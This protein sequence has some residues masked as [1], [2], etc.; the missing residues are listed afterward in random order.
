[1]SCKLHWRINNVADGTST[2]LVPEPLMLV[3]RVCTGIRCLLGEASQ[4]VVRAWD[5]GVAEPKKLIHGLK[6]G[7]ALSLVSLFYY[8]R[9]L[10]EG[11]GGNAMWAIM[12]VVVVFEFTVG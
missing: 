12:T 10:Y 1:M 11:V 4:F 6:V 9:P 7:M 5:M 2:E 8:M 3:R